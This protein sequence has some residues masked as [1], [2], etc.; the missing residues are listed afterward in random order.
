MTQPTDPHLADLLELKQI[1]HGTEAEAY[2]WPRLMKRLDELIQARQ[3][4]EKRP[5]KELRAAHD[6]TA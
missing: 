1:A 4:A 6:Q 3:A 2:T 5:E